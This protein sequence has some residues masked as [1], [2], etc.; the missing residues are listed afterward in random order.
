MTLTS[1]LLTLKLVDMWRFVGS[2]FYTTFLYSVM[3][4]FRWL[5]INS[6][7]LVA[8]RKGVFIATQLN[9]TRRRVELCRYKHPLTFCLFVGYARAPTTKISRSPTHVESDSYLSP[10]HATL[11]LDEVLEGRIKIPAVWWSLTTYDWLITNWSISFQNVSYMTFNKT[12]FKSQL[13]KAGLYAMSMSVCLFV[14]SS[15]CCL[16]NL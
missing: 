5:D 8:Y 4:L 3:S 13:A 16:W 1:D 2:I 9:S 11:L 10:K 12:I 7:D 15:V 6:N 14:R